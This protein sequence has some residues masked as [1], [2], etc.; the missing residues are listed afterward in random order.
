MTVAAIG[1]V[2]SLLTIADAP[3]GKLEVTVPEFAARD[4]SIADFGAK[5][6]GT[7][8]TDDVCSVGSFWH[9]VMLLQ[10]WQ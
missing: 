9:S 3:F 8:C 2:A 4:F 1:L 5:P 7:K 10:C 6:D